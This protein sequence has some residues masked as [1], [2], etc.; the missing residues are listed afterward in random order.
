MY[1][2]NVP[3]QQC[4]TLSLFDESLIPQATKGKSGISQK[5]ILGR[6]RNGSNVKAVGRCALL[7][8]NINLFLGR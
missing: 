5:I 1:E 6:R 2:K 8:T 3:Y 7:I 4:M